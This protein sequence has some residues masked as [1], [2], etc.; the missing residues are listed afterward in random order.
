MISMQQ[1]IHN[2]TF[3]E[4][5]IVNTGGSPGQWKILAFGCWYLSQILFKPTLKGIELLNLKDI[6]IS[7]STTK[8]KNKNHRTSLYSWALKA[9]QHIHIYT[10][11]INNSGWQALFEQFQSKFFVGKCEIPKICHDSSR[12][13]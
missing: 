3:T 7:T 5:H 9:S 11:L 1:E 2:P 10:M 8:H 13:F 12:L 4:F 6:N